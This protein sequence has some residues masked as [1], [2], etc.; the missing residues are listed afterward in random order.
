[1]TV[2]TLID[3][4]IGPLLAT[5]DFS[6]DAASGH[7]NGPAITALYPPGHVRAATPAGT[8]D[9][10][11][12]TELRRQLDQYFAG[13]RR[14][15]DVPLAAVGTAFQE[16]VWKQLR[17]I[18]YAETASYSELAQRIGSP[19]AMRAVGGANARNPISILVPCHRVIGSNGL[20][21]GYAGGL[22]AKR[23]LLEHERAHL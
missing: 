7:G 16:A 22:D 5:G 2:H 9:D 18:A 1:M 13:T 6:G 8:R 23:W 20:P 3:S 10:A 12:F 15:F 11:A 14:D 21:V 4:P 19:R 17:E